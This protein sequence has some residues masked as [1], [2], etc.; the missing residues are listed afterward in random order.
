M[1]VA[2]LF[3]WI[4][5][6][7]IVCAAYALRPFVPSDSVNLGLLLWLV[8]GLIVGVA[9]YLWR[10]PLPRVF[11]RAD[12]A[13][14]TNGQPPVRWSLTFLGA[15]A[16][17]L[18]AEINGRLFL[19]RP[20]LAVSYHLQFALLVIGCLL[21][22]I[23]LCGWR[24][25]DLRRGVNWRAT[26]PVFLITLLALVLNS[27]RLE[28][29]VHIWI[30]EFHFAA[31][32]VRLWKNPS[33]LLL[34]PY[35]G[36]AAFSSIYV[37]LQSLSLRIF[38]PELTGLRAVSVVFGTLTI[39]AMYLL[40]CELFDRKT[41]LL[42]ALFLA[43]FPPQ[44]HFSRLGL[45]N[46][47]DPLFGVLALAFL[48]RGL[49]RGKRVDYVISGIALGLTQYFYEG[50]KLLY[51]ALIVIWL[52]LIVVFWRP[53]GQKHGLLAMALATLLVA[54]PVYYLLIGKTSPVM[55]RLDDLTIAR[56]YFSPERVSTVAEFYEKSLKPP[57]LHFIYTPD[58]SH[59]FYAGE[60]GMILVYV[61]PAFMLG[62][63]VALWRLR[64]VGALLL[65]W[66]VGTIV[67]N[68]LIVQST[69][70][71]RFVVVFPA[72]ALLV[73]AGI[74]YTLPL[75]W[76]FSRSSTTVTVLAALAFTL[77]QTVYYFGPHLTAYNRQVRPFRDHIDVMYRIRGLLPNIYVY[78]IHSKSTFFM[79]HL[80]T[81]TDFWNIPQV[82]TVLDATPDTYKLIESLPRG[83]DYAFFVEPDDSNTITLLHQQFAL[84][85]PRYS[86][87]N[88]PQDKQY[89]MLFASAVYNR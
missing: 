11:S 89:V 7:V 79:P 54:M 8:G 22:L 29:A 18:L 33:Y 21:V 13:D 60:T 24:M 84:S 55:P 52:A 20:L 16:L 36:I 35:E 42:A 51:P 88:V 28:D 66:V 43:T 2:R 78:V 37:Y 9:F 3:A 19:I 48:V 77:P 45:N 63:F 82:V 32:V 85:Q 12:V 81:L 58:D 6:V 57:L 38:G 31:G 40:A 34:P 59:F 1:R 68:S 53:N 75:L 76:P 39:P 72:V 49:K 67:G 41:A 61:V 14:E 83:F 80:E 44:I 69:W 15:A 23:G 47:A 74:R 70:T 62:I 10:Q 86:P 27:W 17:L 30:D 65:V 5:L 4:A 50:G 56:V 26:W 46:I 71:A 64:F 25:A 87:Y 73:V